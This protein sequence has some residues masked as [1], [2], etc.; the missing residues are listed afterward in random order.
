[1]W[2]DPEVVGENAPVLV[3]VLNDFADLARAKR[4]LVLTSAILNARSV[5]FRVK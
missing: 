4:L 3:V 2:E 1:M 5:S